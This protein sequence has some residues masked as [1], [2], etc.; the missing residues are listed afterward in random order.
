M[1]RLTTLPLACLLLLGASGCQPEV[2]APEAPKGPA[3]PAQL[4]V[5]SADT[6]A[7]NVN[8]LVTAGTVSR[9]VQDWASNKP[10]DGEL[11]VLQLDE[12]PGAAKWIA[13]A[14]GVRAYHA[15]QLLQVL[16]P[17]NNGVLAVGTVPAN[18]SRLDTFLRR[19]DIDPRTDLVLFASGTSNALTASQLARAWLAFRYWGFA[20]EHL[21]LLDGPAS[22]VTTLADSHLPQPFTGTERVLSLPE[23]FSLLA[24]LGAVKAAIGQERLLD[25]R[26]REEFEGQVPSVSTLDAT[27][28]DGLSKC[29][30]TF[31]GRIAGA[32]HLPSTR[33][34][35][36]ARFRSLAEL[37][38]LQ[39]E[40]TRPVIVYDADG[41]D[42]A[43][44][45]FALLGVLGV[46]ARWYAPGFVEWGALNASHPSSGLQSLPASSAWRTDVESLSQLGAWADV[47]A[48]VRPLVF[49]AAAPSADQ[50]QV[51]DRAYRIEAPALPA[52]GISE[53]SCR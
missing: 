8:G 35:D 12:A 20:H 52:V 19:F 5:R 25:V 13:S 29:T 50:V 7:Q 14:P 4:A 36:G 21:A 2:P 30:A 47:G 42:S 51:A 46:P 10:V 48:G 16:L 49:D 40:R 6:Y 31:A 43:L 37:D 26:T 1:T 32:T 34:F 28:L 38:A 9:W 17:R 18:G 39:L 27:C 45:T 33:F 11:I 3:T 23:H 44:V 24:D 41:H 53:E 22:D 15:P